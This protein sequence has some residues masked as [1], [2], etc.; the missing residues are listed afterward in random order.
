MDVIVVHRQVAVSDLIPCVESCDAFSEFGDEVH[1]GM[2]QGLMREKS[3]SKKGTDSIH[4][5][6]HFMYIL[7]I[8][9]VHFTAGGTL[10]RLFSYMNGYRWVDEIQI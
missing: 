2:L 3:K 8:F 10:Y 5:S 6:V 9:Y 1:H 4:D 7:C